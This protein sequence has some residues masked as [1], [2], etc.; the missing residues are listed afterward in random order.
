MS[1]REMIVNATNMNIELMFEQKRATADS[2]KSLVG[3]YMSRYFQLDDKN[4]KLEAEVSSLK[5]EISLLKEQLFFL[6]SSSSLKEEL[7]LTE[8]SSSE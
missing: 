8:S 3:E 2:I 1:I 4:S 5:K 7:V 6:K